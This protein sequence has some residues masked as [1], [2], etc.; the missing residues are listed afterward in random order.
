LRTDLAKL[1]PA[2]TIDS[3]ECRYTICRLVWRGSQSEEGKLLRVINVLYPPES[4]EFGRDHTFYLTYK[5]QVFY[6]DVQVGDANSLLNGM[7]AARSQ[8]LD[9]IRRLA[10]LAESY[11]KKMPDQR[12]PD[13]AWPDK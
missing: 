6:R 1:L 4:L 12:I 7:S 8:Q 9:Q 5:G 2:V 3:V 10:K 11:G 13:E